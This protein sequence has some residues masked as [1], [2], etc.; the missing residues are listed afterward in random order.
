MIAYLSRAPIKAR[1]CSYQRVSSIIKKISKV[2]R[3]KLYIIDFQCCHQKKSTRW[4][5]SPPK[6][7]NC[8]QCRRLQRHP[9]HRHVESLRVV[10]CKGSPET[11][12]FYT[13][14]DFPCGSQSRVPLEHVN[15]G[16]YFARLPRVTWLP[17]EKVAFCALWISYAVS[18]VWPSGILEVPFCRAGHSWLSRST[19]RWLTFL[20]MRRAVPPSLLWDLIHSGKL[21]RPRRQNGPSSLT[22]CNLACSIIDEAHS[23]VIK[24]NK[25]ENKKSAAILRF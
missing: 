2:I 24:T 17:Q 5:K 1:A 25:V 6:I 15:I 19:W 16:T 3:I 22:R 14:L 11:T 23:Y 21:T 18:L 9:H 10:T 7:E 13:I 20:T 4:S 8:A 12:L